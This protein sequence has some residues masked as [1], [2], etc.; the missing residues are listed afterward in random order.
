M[1]EK[2]KSIFLIV[3]SI[4]FKSKALNKNNIL[5]SNMMIRNNVFWFKIKRK[6]MF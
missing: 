2:E 5:R 3:K 1:Q 6:Q 4:N